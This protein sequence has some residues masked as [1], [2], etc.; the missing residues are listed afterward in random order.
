MDDLQILLKAV[1]DENSQSSLDS[2]LAKIAKN[3]SESHTVKLKVEFDES[4][5]KTVQTQLQAIAKQVSSASRGSANDASK[6]SLRVFD[7]AKLKADGQMYFN[8][9]RDI[10]SRA[11]KEF[12]KLGKTDI[13]NVFKDA[14][15]NIQSFTASVTKADGV[16]EKFNFNLAKIKNGSRSMRGFVQSNS[17]LSDKNAGTN[18]EQTLNYLNRVNTTIKDITSKTLTNTSRP[19]LGDMQQYTQYQERL[20]AVNARIEEI[21]KTNSTLSAEHKREIDTMIADLKR[22]ANELQTSAYAPSKLKANTFDMQ[23][24]EMQAVLDTQIKKWQNSGI[25][26][27]DFKASVE[28]AKAQLN[29]ALNTNDLDA[30]RHKFALLEQQFR[31]FKLDNTASGNPLKADTLNANIQTLQKRIL[32]LRQTYSAFVSDPDLS[33]RWNELFDDSK[34]ISTQQEL[35]NVRAKLRLFEQDLISAEKHQQ[36]YLGTLKDDIVKMGKWMVL[37]GVIAGVMRGINGLYDAVVDLDTAMTELKKVTD[38]TDVAYDRFLSDAAQKA[39]DIG[40]TYS[41]YVTATANFAR[42]GYDMGDASNLA[43]VATIYSVVGDEISNVDEATSSIISTMKAFGIEAGDAMSIVDKFNKIGN[44]FAISSGGVGDAL[45]RSASA[46]AAANNTIDESIALIVAANNVVQD[47]AAVGTMWKTVSMRIRGAKTELEEAGL[48]TEYMAESTAKLQ[49]QIKALTNVD[50]TGGFDIMADSE[51]FKS[52]YEIILG[53]SKV[54]E[55]MSDIDQAALLE[56]L[57]G[58]RQ[59]NALAAAIENM[60]DAVAAMNASVNS[61]GSALAEH[62]KWMESIQA[63]QQK[64]QAQYQTFA[65]TLLNSDLIKFAYDAGTGILGFFTDLTNAVGALPPLFAAITPFFDKLQAFKTVKADGENSLFGSGSNIVSFKKAAQ[66]QLD[67]D[68]GLLEDYN[69]KVAGLGNSVDDLTKKQIVWND[70]IGRGSDRL[71]AQVKFT[72]TATVS[73]SQYKGAMT[74]ASTGAKGL[75]VSSKVAAVGVNILNTAINMLI[76]FG[77]GLAISAIS[78]LITKLANARQEAIDTANATIE[79]KN[80]ILEETEALKSAY[81]EYKK[82]ASITNRTADEEASLQ[83]AV[84]NVNKILGEKAGVLD[85]LTV[86]TDTYTQALD[87]QIK[88]ELELAN[89]AAKEKRNAAET[90]LQET[91]WSGWSGSEITIDLSGRTGIEDFVSAYETAQRVMGDYFDERTY[92]KELEPIGWDSN[93]KDMG[94][95]VD[96][97]Y[98]LI[99]LQHELAKEDNMNNDIYKDSKEITDALTESVN[100]Y[101]QAKYDELATAYDFNNGTP[102]NIEEFKKYREYLRDNLG[103]ELSFDGLN[104]EIDS[105]LSGTPVYQEYLKQIIAEEQAAKEIGDKMQAISEALIPPTYK[106]YEEGTSAHFHELDAWAAKAEEVKEKLRGLSDEDFNVAYDMVINQGATTWDE[107]AAAIAEYNSETAVA[108]RHAESLQA[109]IKSL[110]N[111]EDFADS[112]DELIKLSTTLDGI[113]A[114]NIKELASDS[115][116]LAAI[117]N[118]DGMNAQ[119]LAHVLQELAEGND[120]GTALVTAQA[121]ELNDA[122]DGMV[123]RFEKVSDA[124]AKYDAAMSVEE[125]DANFKSYAEAFEELNKQFEAGTTNSNAFWAA[126]EFLFGSDQLSAWG[127]SD[128]LDEIYAAMEKNKTVFSDADTA[129]AGFIERLYQMSEAGQ[130]VNEN[131][132]KLLEISKDSD[133]AYNLD[134]DPENL[135]TVAEKMGLTTDAVMACLEALS[136]WG[137]IDFYDMTE[138]VDIIDKIGLSAETAAGKAINV[139]ALIDQL[140]SLGKNDKE[141]HDITKRLQELDGVVLLDAE[142]SVDS[143]T[144]SLTDLELAADDGVTIKVDAEA[145][146]PVLSNLQFTK[147]QAQELITKLG[148]ADGITLTNSQGEVKSLSDALEYLNGLDFATVTSNV[149]GVAG[150]VQDMDAEKTDNVVDQFSNIETAAGEAETAVKKV[151]TAVKNLDGQTAVVTIDTKRK[152]G[153]LS[154]IFSHASGTDSAPAGKALVGEEGAELVQSGNQAYLAGTHGAEIVDLNQGDRV[155]TASETKGILHRSGKQL[156]GVIPAYKNGTPDYNGRVATSGLKVQTDKK[157]ANGTNVKLN[158]DVKATIDNK[159]LEKQLEDTLKDLEDQLSD[160]I[161]NFEHNIFLLEKNDGTPEQIV[162]I[163]RKMQETVHAQ[164]N[165]YR[166]MGL[167]ETSDYIQDLQKK[168]WDYQDQITEILHNIYQTAVDNHKNALSLLENQYEMLDNSQTKDAMLDNLYKQLEEQKAIQD[169]AHQEERRLR[170]LGV[171]ENDDAVQECIDAWHSAEQSIRDISSQIADNILSEFDDLID[172]ADDLNLWKNYDFTKVDVLK[173]KLKEINRL[174]SEGVLTLK[175]YNSLMRETGVEIYNEQKDA[176]TEIIEKTMELVRQE[177]DDQVSALEDQI[178]AYKRI[179]ELKKES[180]SNTK[181]EEDYQT[182]V[183]KKVAEIAEKQ[184]KLAQLDRDTSR[185]SNAEKQKLA[186]ELADLQQELADYQSDYAYDSQVDALDKEADA[187]ES[188]KNDEISY[189]KST[190]DTEEKVYNAAISRINSNW[191]QLYQDLIAWNK[192]YG[193]MI[194]GEDSITSAWKTAKAA[195]QE[196]G[197]VVSALSGINSEISYAGQQAD[198]KQ[199]QIDRI[200]SQMS[201]NGKGW[202]TAKTQEE[203]NRLVKEN[204]DLAEQLSALLGRKVVKVNGVWYLDSANG[205]RLFHTGLEQGYVGGSAYGSQEVLSVLKKGEVVMNEDDIARTYDALT[206]GVDTAVRRMASSG[207]AASGTLGSVMNSNTDNSSVD[208]HI[209]IENH[210]NMHNVTKET[211]KEF[212][213]YYSDYTIGKLMS[214]AKRKGLKNSF[215]NSMLR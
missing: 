176:L 203:K 106:N 58:K 124:K 89:I 91:V 136:M 192:Q 138:V 97:Y 70:T 11:Q 194:D 39:V 166:S 191:N 88:K 200:L 198:S 46:M 53:V 111:S 190:V 165:K 50:G 31:Q 128:G 118:E 137:D 100:N 163:Y 113:T 57:A 72:D 150:A 209:A 107:I 132:E 180:L 155:Y 19:L 210:F 16:V 67:F 201:A 45:Q 143:L 215:T 121:L 80:A 170:D 152:G 169:A 40:T 65:N 54:W 167:D 81:A 161:G 197:D 158:A 28:E 187:F 205:P 146:V 95:V 153:I 30:Y 183:A 82:Y 9:V 60:D 177:A 8:S 51:N 206:N 37:G 71:K 26:G 151:Q 181:D 114:D 145:L 202:H 171:D 189:V 92:G 157:G 41:D 211:A 33:A 73:A 115:S 27:G 188:T 84:E 56:L 125:K 135:D 13:T 122:L 52:T 212:A 214:A 104:D 123:E 140:I 61:E 77:I 18:L 49:K 24:S 156:S 101:V 126:A 42:L 14:K 68:A 17:I 195:A 184:A 6:Q 130:L 168:W 134:I 43:E 213:E 36:S 133:G 63:K 62:E 110:W 12:S 7:S 186:Q 185:S 25:F 147:D 116:A 4:S 98:K 162:A 141:I 149:D 139:S 55:K 131:G 83:T 144:Q 44:E 10:V 3:L 74:G 47:P 1:I 79:E 178:D 86:G 64:F 15:G 94:A 117:L 172:R 129:G 38:E 174:F 5:V 21:K 175:E 108:Q 35:T 148:E 2:K 59:G 196:Y 85:G 32:N 193:D 179:I 112:K 173:Q 69:T 207:H 48:E 109:S 87:E 99:E 34:V 103:D 182:T 105:Y 208:E 93:H 204:E 96:Y 119:F 75:G 66:L 78:N 120:S 159:N 154:S 23:K 102:S 160:I 29:S 22:Y 20:A 199:A 90:A 142:G 127:W 164:A 76:G